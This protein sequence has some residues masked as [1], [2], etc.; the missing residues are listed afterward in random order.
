MKLTQKAQEKILK[1]LF[2]KGKENVFSVV[3]MVCAL[4]NLTWR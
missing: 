1:R 4:R 2:K 3:F